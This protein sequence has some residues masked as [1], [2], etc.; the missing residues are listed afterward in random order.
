MFSQAV[1]DQWH[2]PDRFR[3]MQN[4]IKTVETLLVR[5]SDPKVALCLESGGN[6]KGVLPPGD[7]NHPNGGGIGGIVLA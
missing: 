5:R 2:N 6:L 7:A 3:R 1:R 4:T